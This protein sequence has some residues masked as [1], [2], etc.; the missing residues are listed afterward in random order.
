MVLGEV[1][2]VSDRHFK[3]ELTTNTREKQ[4]ERGGREEGERKRRREG[5]RG[6]GTGGGRF[7]L[8]AV[9]VSTPF[10]SIE[11]RHTRTQTNTPL[12]TLKIAPRACTI[13]YKLLLLLLA[14]RP[15]FSLPPLPAP[16]MPKK[17]RAG[18]PRGRDQKGDRG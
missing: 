16:L 17:W 8:V 13:L 2:E 10:D 18:T 1:I 6:G 15:S 3:R 9:S 11:N 12:L 7:C 5:E 4:R 14:P